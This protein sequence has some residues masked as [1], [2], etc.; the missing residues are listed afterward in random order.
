[1]ILLED[2]RSYS[3]GKL[4]GCKDEEVKVVST[5]DSVLIVEGAN[6]RFPVK[7]EKVGDGPGKNIQVEEYG[8][9]AGDSQRVPVLPRTETSKPLA[10]NIKPAKNRPG[11]DMGLQGSLF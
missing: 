5:R 11:K 8:G 4:Y 2:I 10:G 1:M 9:C 3:S 6:G 7:A